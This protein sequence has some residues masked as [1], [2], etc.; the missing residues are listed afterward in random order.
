[1]ANAMQ[2]ESTTDRIWVG[3]VPGQP[4]GDISCS[5]RGGLQVEFWQVRVKKIGKLRDCGRMRTNI[6]SDYGVKITRT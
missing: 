1:M 6:F 3:R 2:I 4:A 5:I